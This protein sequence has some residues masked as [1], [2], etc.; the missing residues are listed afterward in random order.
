MEDLTGRQFGPY[1]VVAPLGEGGMAAVYKAYQPSVDRYVAL[2]VL[3]QH[4]A[5]DPEFV[6]RFK[7]EAKVIANL[8]HPHILPVHDFGESDG[9][10]YMAMRFIRGGEL[11]Q[12]IEKNQPLSLPQ[13]RRIISQI[14]DALDYAHAQGVMHRDVKPSNVLIDE[15]GNCLLTDFGLARM[16][17]TSVKITRTGGILGTPAYMS[18][19]QGMGQGIDHRSDI[20]ALGVVLY[21]MVTGRPPYQA[22]TPMAIMI[23]HIQSPLP[24][25]TKYNPDLPEDVERVILKALAKEKEDRFAT[26]GDLVKALEKATAHPTISTGAARPT[27]AAI[28]TPQEQEAETAVPATPP[29]PVPVQD[30]VETAVPATPPT[31]VP[32][33]DDVETAVIDTPTDTPKPRRNLRKWALIGIGVIV[34]GFIGLILLSLLDDSDDFEDV[35]PFTGEIPAD[36]A[37]IIDEANADWDEGDLEEAL[38]GFEEA[39]DLEPGIADLHCQ[40]GNLYEII[41]DLYTAFDSYLNC[42]Q[43]AE[44]AGDLETASYAFGTATIIQIRQ[45]EQEGDADLENLQ[46]AFDNAISD[47]LAPDWLICDRGEFSLGYADMEAAFEDFTVCNDTVS[48]PYWSFRSEAVINMIKGQEALSNEDFPIAVEHLQRWAELDPEGPWA[49]CS[50]GYAFNG[51]SDYGAAH[52]AFGQ[53]AEIAELNNDIELRNQAESGILFTIAQ[54]AKINNAYEE[55]LDAFSQAIEITPDTPWLYCERGE[56]NWALD[57]IDQA[58]NDF[59]S[60]LDMSDGDERLSEWANSALSELP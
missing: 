30:D 9:Y 59:G 20:Y 48:D 41:G 17:E 47:S 57:K 15:R 25:P 28:H 22:E 50:L 42:Q 37:G 5:K 49:F 44:N 55:A 29:T 7:R 14:G 24:P 45:M 23:K 54:E 18:P 40:R 2:K 11:S 38:E 46:S 58:R 16:V 27:V 34:V 6:E 3:P 43:I 26:A 35:E 13:I 36:I 53:C 8:Q 51:L 56:V 60:C 39:I 33:Q 31:P 1:Q 12:W 52:D 10:T 21:E 19:E 32:V 4:F